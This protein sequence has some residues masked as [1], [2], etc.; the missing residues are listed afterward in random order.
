[1]QAAGSVGNCF[2]FMIFKRAG[3]TDGWKTYW[4][5]GGEGSEQSVE[6]RPM[7]Q[8]SKNC[9]GQ[10]FISASNRSQEEE[11]IA[12]DVVRSNVR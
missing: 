5:N 4:Q 7:Q 11:V 10:R 9:G 12:P 2:G 1:M 6:G 3:G 8:G